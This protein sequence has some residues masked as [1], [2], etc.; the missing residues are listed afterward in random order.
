M[1]TGGR[2]RRGDTV[3]QV[4][5]EEARQ[6]IRE[7]VLGLDRRDRLRATRSQEG[8]RGRGRVQG[9]S[10]AQRVPPAIGVD[11]LLAASWELQPGRMKPSW[12]GLGQT[13]S[14]QLGTLAK[15]ALAV[16]RKSIWATMEVQSRL[17]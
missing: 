13:V 15:P 11:V 3:G 14:V 17:G 16:M 1:S 12:S 6:C 2:S 10:G 8:Y 9:C 7:E 5:L 4:Q